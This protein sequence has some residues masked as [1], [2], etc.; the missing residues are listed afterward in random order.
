[1]RQQATDDAAAVSL[2]SRGAQGLCL[3][4]DKRFKVHHTGKAQELLHCFPI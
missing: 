4:D 1:M 2:Q 3:M